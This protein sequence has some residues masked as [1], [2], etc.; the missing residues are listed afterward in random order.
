RDADRGQQGSI[1]YSNLDQTATT[2]TTASVH[3]QPVRAT[4]SS[5]SLANWHAIPEQQQQ[6]LSGQP[7]IYEI[8]GEAVAY[9]HQ[10]QNLQPPVA[11]P[12]DLVSGY[13]PQL[14][15]GA[16]AARA[17]TLI[18]PQV[19]NPAAN[20]SAF[21][22]SSVAYHQNQQQNVYSRAA[23]QGY[24]DARAQQHQS[25]ELARPHAQTGNTVSQGQMYSPTSP[26]KS[27][28]QADMYQQTPLGSS[29]SVAILNGAIL[30]QHH[31]YTLPASSSLIAPSPLSYKAEAQYHHQQ[32]AQTS[33]PVH[34]F[35][36]GASDSAS[37]FII[38]NSSTDVT[39]CVRPQK[40]Q[41]PVAAT[42]TC[43]SSH[44]GW[45]DVPPTPSAPIAHSEPIHRHHQQAQNHQQKV[46]VVEQAYAPHEVRADV[47]IVKIRAV[48]IRAPI[49]NQ[50]LPAPLHP[51]TTTAQAR[52][53]AQN[54]ARPLGRSATMPDLSPC[55]P[56][57]QQP[58]DRLSPSRT[59]AEFDVSVRHIEAI[60]NSDHIR[61]AVEL[62]GDVGNADP[63]SPASHKARVKARTHQRK[64]Q[65]VPY[66]KDHPLTRP[67]SIFAEH[68]HHDTQ[69]HCHDNQ[70]RHLV[71]S[72]APAEQRTA[73]HSAANKPFQHQT[74]GLSNPEDEGKDLAAERREADAA[75]VA[76]AVMG[77]ERKPFLACAF[78]RQHKA[79]PV[80]K[81]I[82]HPDG[83]EDTI[84]VEEEEEEVD[85]KSGANRRKKGRGPIEWIP[86]V[87]AW[88][89]CPIAW[90]AYLAA[91]ELK[92]AE[93]EVA[94]AAE[95]AA[96]ALAR[97]LSPPHHHSRIE[98]YASAPPPPSQLVRTAPV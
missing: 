24:A 91:L 90:A 86:A 41:A 74:I 26:S 96:A 77:V 65:S 8:P 94:K 95:A 45:A 84:Y 78:C 71:P 11:S 62:H 52:S 22:E 20:S 87:D 53:Q 38:T 40:P 18:F 9:H 47:P 72:S 19:Y 64:Q 48:K 75:S 42:P 12:V 80:A 2:S 69:G 27:L 89:I 68:D 30:S 88:L 3:P 54:Q 10:Y 70:P 1:G 15:A 16:A 43:T 31:Q 36:P 46:A 97:K 34:S 44:A 14:S 82:V 93:A 35:Q 6:Y 7:Q 25:R 92:K 60:K 4:T 17:G 37:D 83:T 13:E 81:S 29:E 61:R 79:K 73:G 57:Q 59:A 33:A 50:P 85:E 56:Q 39:V 63:S 67:P 66:P 28:Y 58:S 23:F 32:Q 5:S 21:L 76:A 51:S 98:G 49:P 55:A